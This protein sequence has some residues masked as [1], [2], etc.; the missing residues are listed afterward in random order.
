MAAGQILELFGHPVGTTGI[1][2]QRTVQRQ[3]CPFTNTRCFKVRKSQPSISIGT[4]TVRYGKGAKDVI[5]CPNRL[6]ERK[7]VFPDCVHLLT[8]HQPGNEFHVIPEVT[9][10]GGSVDYFLVSAKRGKVRDFVA[11]EFQTLDTTG[12]VWPERQRALKAL[13]LPVRP[14]DIRSKKGFGMNWKMTAKTIL[15]QL[16]HK[17]KT[18]EHISKHLVLVV[19]NHLL[20]YMRE[21]FD[22]AHLSDARVGD[23]MHFHSYRLNECSA[24]WRLELESRVS[25]DAEGIARCLGLQAEAKVELEVIIAE[26]EKKL[27]AN[28]ILTLGPNPI[29]PVE[30]MPTA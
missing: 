2:W 19:Q 14:D 7:Q 13:G 30:Q 10:P 4:C 9:I 16:H 23:S 20:D 22:F 3:W 24:A 5:I 29:A 26:L 17:I 21:E 8:L 27:S 15:V 6:L 18:F 25:T 1:G 11:I 12:T 28:T